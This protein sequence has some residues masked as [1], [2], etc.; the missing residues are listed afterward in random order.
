[1]TYWREKKT[2]PTKT[3]EPNLVHLGDYADVE[4]FV[5]QLMY[6]NASNFFPEDLWQYV[7]SELDGLLT[8]DEFITMA[9]QSW[10]YYADLEDVDAFYQDNKEEEEDWKWQY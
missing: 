8:E 1:M 6:Q 3:I 10:A 9:Y 2:S 4:S 7:S 5:D